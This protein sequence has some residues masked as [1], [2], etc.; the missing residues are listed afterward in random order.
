MEN[1][2]GWK[3]ENL[4]FMFMF[5]FVEEELEWGMKKYYEMNGRR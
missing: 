4:V 5:L 1:I 3:Y 2:F